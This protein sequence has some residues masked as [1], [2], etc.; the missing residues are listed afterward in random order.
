MVDFT[1]IPLLILL[2][3]GLVLTFYGRRVLKTVA[4]LI[5]AIIGATIGLYL[6]L[7]LSG[8]TP[9]GPTLWH[10]NRDRSQVL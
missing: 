3:I 7:A 6:G 8:L 2:I 10:I 5:G 9:L 1:A 4:F